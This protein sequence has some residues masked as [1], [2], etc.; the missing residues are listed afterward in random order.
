ML[1]SGKGL[2]STRVADPDSIAR[3]ESEEFEAFR[4]AIEQFNPPHEVHDDWVEASDH[5][6]EVVVKFAKTWDERTRFHREDA[7]AGLLYLR[8]FNT[9]GIPGGA[10]DSKTD[11]DN[12]RPS[13]WWTG[14]V[15]LSGIGM[16]ALA[17]L[18]IAYSITI[19]HPLLL[20]PLLFASVLFVLAGMLNLHDK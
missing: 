2:D 20:L 19:V 16:A 13:A 9:T 10:A 4:E 18:Q 6:G 14:V 8:R 11:S 3:Q 12:V 7:S 5:T 1:T 17:V 15:S